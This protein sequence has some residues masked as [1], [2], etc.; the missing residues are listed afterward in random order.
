L[1]HSAADTPSV[2]QTPSPNPSAMISTETSATKKDQTADDALTKELTDVPSVTIVEAPLRSDT[3]LPE[4]PDHSKFDEWLKKNPQLTQPFEG[5]TGKRAAAL[6]EPR[7]NRSLSPA[8]SENNGDAPSP[9]PK[10]LRN[11]LKK[12]FSALPRA[13]SRSS[14]SGRVS[15]EYSSRTP[16]PSLRLSPAQKIKSTNPAALFCHEVYSQNTTLQR[17][18]IYTAK[19]NELYIHDCGLSE[20]LIETKTRGSLYSLFILAIC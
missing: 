10:S 8:S 6:E 17:C 18:A 11:S 15:S 16:S 12:R 3:Q 19:I 13:S 1:E 2:T 4:K 7:R 9:P 14:R 20:W 5:D